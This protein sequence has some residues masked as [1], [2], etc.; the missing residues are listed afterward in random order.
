M[1]SRR[2]TQYEVPAGENLEASAGSTYVP[3]RVSGGRLAELDGVRGLAIAL[4]VLCHYGSQQ[5][6]GAPRG[7]VPWALAIIMDMGWVGVDLFFVLSGFLI[8]GIL[9]DNRQSPRFFQT[10]Y[11]RRVCRI[12]PLYYAWL[13]ITLVLFF[14]VGLSPYWR[15]LMRPDVPFWSYLTYTQN[16]LLP[17]F[18]DFG[19]PWYGVTWSLAVEEQ[20]YLLFPVLIRLCPPGKLPGVLLALAVSAN[21]SR[22]LAWQFLP[23]PGL[24]GFVLLPC[25]WDS[26]FLGA[27]TAWTV[28]QAWFAEWFRRKERVILLVGGLILAVLAGLR[29]VRHGDLRS[30]V[31]HM[32]GFT[33]LAILF[34]ALLVLAVYSRMRW[35]RTVFQSRLL[36]GLGMISYGVYLL[37]QPVSWITHAAFW[38]Q[39]PQMTGLSTALTTL[40]ALAATLTVAAISWRYFESR[41]VGWGRKWTY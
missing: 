9:I 26:L 41:F 20:F 17:G 31:M 28:R 30:P 2:V 8:G 24:A 22:V 11:V 25:R 3:G 37:H 39:E 10:F 15:D 32:V 16:F 23:A 34:S 6:G 14:L 13:G 12:F 5:I 7:S 27:L 33:L 18:G 21:I 19:K 40:F 38:R 36:R 1:G 29:L 35:I 4:V